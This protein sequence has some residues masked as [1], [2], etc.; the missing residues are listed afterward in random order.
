MENLKKTLGKQ[1]FFFLTSNYKLLQYPEEE[2][3]EMAYG[4]HTDWVR[5]F[6]ESKSAKLKK[7]EDDTDS[8]KNFSD[9][10]RIT[11]SLR[12]PSF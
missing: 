4:L 7:E 10:K 8:E 9:C 3:A 1:F 5:A 2:N 12:K 6:L 11:S